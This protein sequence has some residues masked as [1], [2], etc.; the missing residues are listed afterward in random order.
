MDSKLRAAHT[1]FLTTV[2]SR[3]FGSVNKEE[4]EE[5]QCSKFTFYVEKRSFFAKSVSF[6]PIGMFLT[7]Q[8]DRPTD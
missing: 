8:C 6:A 4:E 7:M 1:Q 2:R 3:T 5:D